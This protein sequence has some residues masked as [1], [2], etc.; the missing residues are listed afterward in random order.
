MTR[1]APADLVHF[2]FP[3]AVMASGLA[4]GY[5]LRTRIREPISASKRFTRFGMTYLDPA[6]VVLALWAQQVAEPRLLLLP[7]T[8]F[9]LTM[10]AAL[11]AVAAARLR[12]M[13]PARAGALVGTSMFSN[14]GPTFG[15]FL[16]FVLAGE[17]GFA[18]AT[19][20]TVYFY[21]TFYT[22]GLLV[23]RRYSTEREIAPWRLFV[24]AMRDPANRNP[25][26]GVGAGLLLSLFGPLRPGALAVVPDLLV[27]ATTFVYL[28]GIGMTLNFGR[29]RQFIPHSLAIGAV[30]FIYTPLL[31]LACI[32]LLAWLGL[33]DSVFHQAVF[34]QACMPAAIF[35]LIMVNLFD[36]ERDLA[37]TVWLF[38]NGL[39]I[40][41]SPLMLFL[42][43]LL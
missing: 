40:L 8:G 22:V 29:V 43:Q 32:P 30:K 27:P 11:P 26:L 31:G 19:L 23:G 10:L 25:L 13:S 21:P 38:T 1:P 4:V 33:T 39:G 6:N 24:E 12:R 9:A 28:T 5:L 37:N 15:T 2:L 20:Y 7:V 35:S 42:A 16:A 41:L 3:L 17:A 14:Q 36:L 18:A 34:I